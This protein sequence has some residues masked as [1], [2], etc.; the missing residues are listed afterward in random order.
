MDMDANQKE[1]DAATLLQL[2]SQTAM[3]EGML[4]QQYKYIQH[5]STPGAG[6][7]QGRTGLYSACRSTQC[8]LAVLSRPQRGWSPVRAQVA[9]E[10]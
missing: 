4:R 3:M 10:R 6:P 5:C 1:G 2:V 7:D 8:C 9:L